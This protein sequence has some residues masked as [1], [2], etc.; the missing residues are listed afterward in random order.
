MKAMIMSA[1]LGTRLKPIT[2][3]IPKALVQ[4][5]N[6][7]M[8]ERVICS[9]RDKGFDYFI[10][11][12]FHFADMIKE[13][14][15]TH[16]FGVEIVVSDESAGLMDTGGGI[17]KALPLIFRDNDDPVLIH[18]VDILSNANP[19]FLMNSVSEG[20]D[21]AALLVS[22]RDSTRKL[23]F[24][25]NNYLKGWH[26]LKEN[27]YKPTDL[28]FEK[29]DKELAFSGIYTFTKKGI[30]EMANLMGETKFPVMDYFLNQKRQQTVKGFELDNLNILDIG[31]PAS[32]VQ[33]SEILRISDTF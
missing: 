24:D 31:K 1:G 28:K 20:K 16:H 4:I 8:L 3:S 21:S 10:V 5:Q 7:T 29:S 26:N 6:R 11:N 9:L 17:V 30:L 23:I 18:N 14:L 25:N 27:I 32:L 33:A 22:Q 12:V 15:D 13:F 2:D 19:L